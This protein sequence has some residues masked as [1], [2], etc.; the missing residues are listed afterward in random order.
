MNL[1]KIALFAGVTQFLA[2][3]GNTINYITWFWNLHGEGYSGFFFWKNVFWQSIYLL[4]HAALTLFFI[5]LVGELKK[6]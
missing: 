5:I 6:E 4:A 3:I 1:R 2:L